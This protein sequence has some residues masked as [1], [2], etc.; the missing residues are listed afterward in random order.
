MIRRRL[1]ASLAALALLAA[2]QSAQAGFAGTV[3]L[4]LGGAIG[5]DTGNVNTAT[6]YSLPPMYYFGSGASGDFNTYLPGGITQVAPAT[7][8]S[9]LNPSAAP[10]VF[11]SFAPGGGFTF[12]ST[13]FGTFTAGQYE[14][15]PSGTQTQSYLFLGSYTLGTDFAGDP[16]GGPG[17][18]LLAT[19]TVSFTQN[20]GPGTPI[21][22]SGTLTLPPTAV[23]EPA[24]AALL[25]LGLVGFGGVALRRR[26]ATK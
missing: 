20:A 24:S 12:G 14:L 18:T 15:I 6:M 2:G 8:I 16:N 4:T 7:T 25:G 11:T 17:T 1:F 5:T 19:I 3:P 21:S 23:P 22:G 9:G 26:T 10:N 13:G